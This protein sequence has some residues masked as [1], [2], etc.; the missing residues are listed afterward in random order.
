LGGSFIV[1]IEELLLFRAAVYFPVFAVGAQGNLYVGVFQGNVV[2]AGAVAGEFE[3]FGDPIGVVIIFQAQ[4][5]VHRQLGG[6]DVAGDG[7]QL[8][9]VVVKGEH[10][11][12][13]HF[14]RKPGESLMCFCAH[15]LGIAEVLFERGVYFSFCG[16]GGFGKG[17]DCQEKSEGEGGN[18]FHTIIF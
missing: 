3:E 5:Q 1:Y 13:V 8:A 16:V 14:E 11:R 10:D 6:D 15:Q 7:Q 12:I 4:Q 18:L 9:A 17:D 2:A